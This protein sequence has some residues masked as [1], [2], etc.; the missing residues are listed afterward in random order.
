M[1]VIYTASVEIEGGRNGR[2]RSDDGRL[3][4][5]TAFPEAMG[6]DGSGTNPEQLLGAAYAA[7]FASSIAHVAKQGGTNLAP[8]HVSAEV[9]V[10]HDGERFELAVRLHVHAGATDRALMAELVERTRNV[11][12]YSRMVH[13]AGLRHDVRVVE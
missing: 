2:V 6:G 5:R 13:D 4:V 1:Q 11:C 7:C 12:P 10:L 3:E 8:P 9:D